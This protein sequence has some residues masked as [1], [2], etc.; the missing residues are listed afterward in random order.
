MGVGAQLRQARNERNLSL[1]EITGQTKIQPWVLE[2]LESDRLQEQMDVIYVRGFV[3]TYARYLGLE[4]E[5]LLAQLRRPDVEPARPQEHWPP[6]P[7]AKPV[8]LDLERLWVPLQRIAA[9]GVA[10]A[11]V[12]GFI[13]GPPLRRMPTATHAGPKATAV[14]STKTASKRTVS[15]VNVQPA[16]AAVTTPAASQAKLASV[17][18][19]SETIKPPPSPPPVAQTKSLELLVTA[20]KTTWIQL[21]ADGKLV[22][23]QRLARGAHERWMATKGFELML[24]KPSQVE[25]TLNGVPISALAIAYH[26]RLR[27][28]HRGV[29]PLPDDH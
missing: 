3:T 8:A 12:A 23:Q 17:V 21:W 16:P 9:A 20:R 28:T 26:G 6:V 18:P 14:A 24:A 4:V 19:V 5:P 7:A 2:A 1:A 22:T 10:I 25:L 13:M 29:T 11:V 15:A 27:I